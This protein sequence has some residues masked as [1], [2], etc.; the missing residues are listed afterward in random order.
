M[1]KVNKYVN[2]VFVLL[3]ITSVLVPAV[4]LVITNREKISESE[5]RKLASF[6]EFFDN[7]GRFNTRL[8]E[9]FDAWL[10]DNIGFRSYFVGIHAMLKVKFLHM[11]TNPTVHFGKEDWYF[12]TPDHNLDI[13]KGKYP[14]TDEMLQKIAFNQQAISD[15][16]RK[17]NITYFLLLT[18]SKASIYPEYISGGN[19]GIR[20]T[21]IDIVTNYLKT[22]TTVNVINSKLYL[23]NDKNKGLVFQ[24]RN[25][26]WTTLGSYAAYKAILERMNE[27]GHMDDQPV[28]VEVITQEY[29]DEFAPMLGYY[30]ILGGN[31]KAAGVIWNENGTLSTS[32]DFYNEIKNICEK[33][34]GALSYFSIINNSKAKY[35]AL[36]IYGDSQ[37][38]AHLKIPFYMAEHYKT[39]VFAGIVPRINVDLEAAV[40]PDAVLF[41]CSERYIIPRL[42][43]SYYAT[44]PV[45]V[46]R[47]DPGVIANLP[48]NSSERNNYGNSGMWID[49]VNKTVLMFSPE[50]LE[51]NENDLFLEGWAVDALSNKPLSALYV[52]VGD[53][54]FRCIYG[55]V[56]PG[57]APTFNN[58]DLTN[59]GFKVRIPRRYLIG[60]S[61]ISFIQ[62]TT[63]GTYRYLPVKYKVNDI[64]GTYASEFMDAK[65]LRQNNSLIAEVR[66]KNT[67]GTKWTWFENT[68]IYIASWAYS[69][70]DVNTGSWSGNGMF[71]SG[72]QVNPGEEYTFR[73]E[74]AGTTGMW[75]RF[76]MVNNMRDGQQSFIGD[77]SGEHKFE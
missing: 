31:E 37:I 10:N 64:A 16:Y 7:N 66:V 73:I 6:P 70:N 2:I 77:W 25:T 44:V 54:I 61:E 34:P 24:K 75:Y 40:Q 15:Y 43:D 67:G 72:I 47:V 11:S 58:P 45:L 4:F 28:T 39:V 22:Y 56:H 60:N 57:V 26:H 65:L 18:P 12:Y 71:E 19:Y 9:E 30:D 20:E 27:A 55:D 50:V 53:K 38:Q 13:A 52:N 74:L 41:S 76:I 69:G 21:P 42:T 14:L 48:V 35:G 3:F 8:K 1:K 49:Y 46:D 59:V 33:Y 36:M 68:G 5:N 29:S 32:G 62:I 23:I 51:I 17:Q 63:D